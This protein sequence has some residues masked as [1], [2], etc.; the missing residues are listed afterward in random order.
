MSLQLSSPLPSISQLT[1]RENIELR[2]NIQSWEIIINHI[3]DN[4]KIM[5]ENPGL[6]ALEITDHYLI[7]TDEFNP[8][9]NLGFRYNYDP[10]CNVYELVSEL[11]I[12]ME[13][14]LQTLGLYGKI[15]FRPKIDPCRR[16][17]VGNFY[18]N[19]GYTI[20][21][22]REFLSSRKKRTLKAYCGVIGYT[23]SI[24]NNKRIQYRL[25]ETEFR[26]K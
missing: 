17:I 1:K 12:N 6:T 9:R 16:I 24:S 22:I 8:Y 10:E 21:S 18:I 3:N 5:L 19:T 20:D 25:L 4:F 26:R 2:N 11:N 15:S 7:C 14:I 23:N 13:V